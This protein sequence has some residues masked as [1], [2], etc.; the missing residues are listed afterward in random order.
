MLHAVPFGSAG[1][2]DGHPD[3]VYDQ[4]SGAILCACLEQD[5]QSRVASL[6]AA[7]KDQTS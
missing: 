5:T 2:S 4:I 1:V 7:T 6:E 3:K